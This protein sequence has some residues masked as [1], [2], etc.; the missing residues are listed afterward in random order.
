MAIDL[1][2]PFV[3]HF[4]NSTYKIYGSDSKT[5]LSGAD[6]VFA[7][8]FN[9]VIRYFPCFTFVQDP[10]VKGFAESNFHARKNDT[11]TIV[12]SCD[13]VLGLKVDFIA[14]GMYKR[15]DFYIILTSPVL[16]QDIQINFGYNGGSYTQSLSITAGGTSVST[17]N[18]IGISTDVNID[19]I[20]NIVGTS[21]SM[22]FNLSAH[23]TTGVN[24]FLNVTKGIEI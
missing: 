8:K 9:D 2:N 3:Y 1:L 4:N 17:G 15:F 21:Q 23:G 13:C 16:L 18:I 24:K 5:D 6:Y 7:K 22:Q 11:T 19:G 10:K 12:H 14:Q 20:I